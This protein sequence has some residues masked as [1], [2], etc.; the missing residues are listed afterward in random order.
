MPEEARKE[1]QA[2]KEPFSVNMLICGVNTRP[3]AAYLV[4][5][6]DFVLGKSSGCDG[7]LD[8]SDEVS[9]EHARIS[10]A[11]GQY[12]I[13]DLNSRN[14]TFLNG[15]KLAGGEAYPLHAGDR[16]GISAFLFS[17]ETVRR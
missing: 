3:C 16:I 15:R 5:K 10:W 8:F 1:A 17:V 6:P 13:T 14:G 4:T 2:E 11:D 12:T 7:V 9:R